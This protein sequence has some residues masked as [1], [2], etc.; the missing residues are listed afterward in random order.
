MLRPTATVTAAL[1]FGNHLVILFRREAVPGEP[2]S[3]GGSTTG[4]GGE[5]L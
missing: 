2:D 5:V 1:S 3:T 4:I